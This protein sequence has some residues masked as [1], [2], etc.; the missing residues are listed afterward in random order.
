MAAKKPRSGLISAIGM[1][2]PNARMVWRTAAICAA[3][4]PSVF[5]SISIRRRIDCW[6]AIQ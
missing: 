2:G 4:S 5:T 6:D 1:R 3:G